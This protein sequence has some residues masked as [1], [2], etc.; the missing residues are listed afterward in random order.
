MLSENIASA[1]RLRAQD[2]ARAATEEGRYVDQGIDFVNPTNSNFDGDWSQP[3]KYCG[4]LHLKHQLK[5]ELPEGGFYF[6]RMPCKQEQYEIRKRAVLQ[7]IVVRTVLFIHSFVIYLWERT[8]FKK[9]FRLIW[10]FVS[11]VFVSIRALVYLAL[12]RR[13]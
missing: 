5:Y 9:E 11:H 13:K 7:G 10:Q 2:A 4:D 8:P 12:S 6:H 1:T 3:C